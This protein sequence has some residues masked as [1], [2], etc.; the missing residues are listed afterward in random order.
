MAAVLT[1]GAAALALQL[2]PKLAVRFVFY[3]LTHTVYRIR[4]FGAENIPQSG[5]ALLVANHVT[6]VDGFLISACMRHLVRFLVDEVWFDRFRPL[7]R[8]I[9]AI[10]VPAGNRRAVLKAIEIA[11]KN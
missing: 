5:P 9:D 8:L 11:G 2:V 10:Q 4:V 3:V 7:F 6:Y 1:L